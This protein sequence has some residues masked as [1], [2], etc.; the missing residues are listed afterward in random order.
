VL[1]T[2]FAESLGPRVSSEPVYRSAGRFA[3]SIVANARVVRRLVTGDP[4]DVWH[5]VFAPN[6][7][8][9]SAARLAHASRRALG[10]KGP[11]VQ[12]VAS[13]PRDFQGSS[14][15]LFG[16]VVIALS[17][18]TRARLLAD[19]AP[20]AKLRVIAPCAAA[21][22]TPSEAAVAAARARYALGEGR[23]VLYPGDYE[24][25][26][27]AATFA[28]SIKTLSRDAPD[29]LFVF[30][31]REKTPRAGASR[32]KLAADL[33]RAGV[34]HRVRHVGEIDDLPALLAASSV[35]AFPVDDLYGKVDVPLVL[36][37]ALA[38]G[39]PLVVARGGP[40][41][42]LTTAAFVEPGD[43]AGLAAA[44]GRLVRGADGADAARAQADRGKELYA[45]K[46][47]PQVVA[48]RHDDLYEEILTGTL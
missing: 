20:G 31:C 45:Q 13:A 30:A 10:W 37:E 27:G 11:V 12:T 3:P 14:A 25:S 42:T 32:E 19:G 24:V 8:S 34:A 48:D 2:P 47:A 4:H 29:V 26:T 35:V 28:E 1:T 6:S 9:S 7:A 44:L 18:W 23:V 15:L 41:E 43:G 36:I 17:E 38:L 46:F 22:P 21:P 40:L 16:D 5:F 39:V 33:A